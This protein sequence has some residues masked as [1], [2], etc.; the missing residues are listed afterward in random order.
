MQTFTCQGSMHL[1]GVQ[2]LLKCCETAC[3]VF[4][5]PSIHILHLLVISTCE[6]VSL[7]SSVTS[8]TLPLPMLKCF[9]CFPNLRSLHTLAGIQ[10]SYLGILGVFIMLKHMYTPVLTDATSCAGILH[11]ATSALQAPA[12][13]TSVT[14]VAW[15]VES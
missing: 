12:L 5:L 15:K 1:E 4:I 10:S 8:S 7:A 14:R 6:S 13:F 2:P 3:V 9:H 11:T